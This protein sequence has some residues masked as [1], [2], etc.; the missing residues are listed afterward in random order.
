MSVRQ[1]KILII[2]MLSCLLAESSFSQPWF[3]DSLRR[4]L[5]LAGSDTSR[6]L[7]LADLCF[8]YRNTNVDSSLYYGQEALELSRKTKFVR[9][10][11]ETLVRLG[12]SY[13]EKGN[14]PKSLELLFRA[15]NISQE[16]GYYK[17]L[18]NAYR[19][20]A[21]VYRDLGEYNRSVSYS[22]LALD[23]D[24][25]INNQRGIATEYMN[26]SISYQLMGNIDSTRYYV[27]KGYEM[28]EHIADLM[29]E[30]YRV[31]GSV[32]VMDGNW[33]KAVDW[34]GQGIEYGRS[35]NDYRT[36]SYIYSNMAEMY[37]N[38]KLRDSA[39]YCAEQ[40]VYYGQKTSYRKG[41]YFSATILSQLFDSVHPAKA[42]HYYKIA[43]AAKDS[44]F[45]AGNIRTLQDLVSR[46]E[47]RQ[48][49]IEM[50]KAAYQNRLK[51]YGLLSGLGIFLIIAAILY[52]NNRQKQKANRVL[53]Q[54]LDD[55]AATQA[56]L[57]H[58]E[59]MASL[60]ELTAGIAHEIQNPLNFVNNFSELN[61]EMLTELKEEIARGN[62]SEALA[63]A[64][65]LIEN[66]GKVNSHGKRADGIVKSM[67]QH[68]RSGSGQKEPV[69]LNALCDE[70]LRLAFQ[71][72]KARD[73]SF[74]VS[75]QTD[76]DP[77][78]GTVAV[79]PQEMGRVLLNLV[80]N[81]LYIVDK[82]A[83]QTGEGYRPEVR[84][85]SRRLGD[86]IE[87]G[88][89][90]NGDGIP[91]TIQDKIFQPFFTTKPTGQGTGLGLSLSYDIVTKAH[92]GELLL[93][94]RPGEYT[95]FI[96]RIPV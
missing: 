3:T 54:T 14:L 51:Q 83:K 25:R 9:G 57:I 22:R 96:I 50:T 26:L 31:L 87:I 8:Y 18:A 80:N 38:L 81:A 70:Y 71:G 29:T 64:D 55:L 63:I 42:L 82:K 86:K 43:A 10:E 28:S 52:R 11:A 72:F 17:T 73:E 6:V 90:D 89:W 40:G 65:D 79:I 53:Q 2:G 35:I 48:K 74:T 15:M 44:L 91:A 62:Y 47:A 61:G 13:R 30:I 41:I 45:G 16:H 77:A 7:I 60:G 85:R 20:I 68:S 49:E 66:E 94:T 27:R 76:L 23:T 59:K 92:G 78:V 24:L 58:A 34:Y 12:L 39:I 37:R 75:L 21:H 84:L 88:V 19:R 33:N 67:L 1:V 95:E 5:S 56:Q 69:D 32:E 93:E 46:E 36:I 4:Q